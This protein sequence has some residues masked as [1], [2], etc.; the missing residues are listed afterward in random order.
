MV[1]TGRAE[2]LGN[3][4]LTSQLGQKFSCKLL[5][6]D[7]Y[8]TDPTATYLFRRREFALYE[9]TSAGFEPTIPASDR[10]HTHSF[11]RAASG[12]GYTY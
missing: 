10:L 5:F 7:S 12:T 4:G 6:S 1:T 2:K 3:V 9:V 11:D 8:K